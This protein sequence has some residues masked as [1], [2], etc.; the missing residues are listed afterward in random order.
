MECH[1]IHRHFIH[2]YFIH[3]LVIYSAKNQQKKHVG[4]SEEVHE[5][6]VQVCD[7]PATFLPAVISTKP[8][9]ALVKTKKPQVNK[10]IKDG[11]PD[12]VPAGPPRSDSIAACHNEKIS[13]DKVDMPNEVQTC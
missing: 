12:D 11:D 2:R 10:P 8:G 9:Q 6:K 5:M 7:M 4:V 13:E 1:V 3:C